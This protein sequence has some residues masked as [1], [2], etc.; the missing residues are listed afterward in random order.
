MK[1]IAFIF[2]LFSFYL[3]G[4]KIYWYFYNPFP[5]PPEHSQKFMSKDDIKKYFAGRGIVTRVFID[6]G[7]TEYIDTGSSESPKSINYEAI[8]KYNA[9]IER[10]RQIIDNLRLNSPQEI[11]EWMREHIKYKETE[12]RQ[13]PEKTVTLGTGSCKDYALLAQRLLKKI[14]IE[15]KVIGFKCIDKKKEISHAICVYRISVCGYYNFFSNDQLYATHRD[16]I[17]DLLDKAYSTR[18]EVKEMGLNPSDDN[19][20]F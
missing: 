18:F 16:T 13:S 6:S 20:L 2:M 19:R 8:E 4:T 15:S 5:S 7:E 10:G 14:N 11:A 3:L 17:R 12:Y 9:E 1:K